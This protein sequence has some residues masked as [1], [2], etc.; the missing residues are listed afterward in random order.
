LRLLGFLA[1][2]VGWS[3]RSY[4]EAADLAKMTRAPPSPI[5]TEL[6][7]PESTES[8]IA[9]LRKLKNEII[10]HDQRKESWI[11]WGIVP[12]LSE[13]LSAR[14]SSGK[15]VPAELNGGKELGRR[16]RSLSAEDEACLQA[17]I[18]VGSFAQGTYITKPLISCLPT[19]GYIHLLPTPPGSLPNSLLIL[20]N[21]RRWC[22]LY[23][24]NTCRKYPPFS[25]LHSIVYELLRPSFP[26]CS[27]NSLYH[28]RPT[29]ERT[30]T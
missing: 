3:R 14:R 1:G 27:Q 21:N 9:A 20:Y 11:T 29:V 6:Q 12:I 19:Y 25:S 16:T 28:C 15:R 10:G 2:H 18:L 5:L 8:Q 7:N 13:I 30:S 17:I 23:I 4:Q 26:C 22:S 24:A